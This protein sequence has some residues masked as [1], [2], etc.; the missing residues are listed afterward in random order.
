M[1]HELKTPLSS[2]RLMLELLEEE[3]DPQQ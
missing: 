1:L 2:V 3:E